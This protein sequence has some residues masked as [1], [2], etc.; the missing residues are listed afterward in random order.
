MEFKVGD[1][2]QHFIF[3]NG[4]IEQVNEEN[5]TYLIKFEQFETLRTISANI[6]LD[7]I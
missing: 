1:K 3:G 4:L 2:V 6:R 7:K 5:R